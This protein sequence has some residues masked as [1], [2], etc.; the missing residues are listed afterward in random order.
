MSRLR[1]EVVVSDGMT[2]GSLPPGLHPLVDGNPEPWMARW[3]EDDF[4]VFAD[5]E[6]KGAAQ[7]MRWVPAGTFRMGSPPGEEGRFDNEG[8]TRH[9]TLTQGLWM[10][11]SPVTQE[12]WVAVIDKNSSWFHGLGRPVERV[13]WEDVA[14]FCMHLNSDV[15]GLAAR[16]PSEAEWERACRAGSDAAR[17][18]D[19]GDI[20]WYAGNSGGETRDVKG[21]C[22]N[23]LGFYD[24]LG[25]VFEWCSEWVFQ[26]FRRAGA[27]DP[28]E[29]GKG[30][31]RVL[32]GGSW[33]DDAD[34]VRAGFRTAK[35]P[36]GRWGNVG[37]R[38]ARGQEAN[39]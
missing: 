13:S 30:Q 9:L 1:R 21:K 39:K 32:R 22:A 11:D 36:N 10:G 3:G 24:M 34:F 4:G 7:R 14:G 26:D 35:A 19:V 38:L 5:F 20:A 23:A 2:P 15:P 12:L 6:V 8:P 37:F 27:V 17:Y 18:G 28:D 25:N 29:P 33:D 16:L 31:K